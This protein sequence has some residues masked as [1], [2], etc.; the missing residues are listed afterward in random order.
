MK[1]RVIKNPLC[2]QKLKEE[3]V[4]ILYLFGS[5]LEGTSTYCS[6]VDL[7][8][9]FTHA[10]FLKNAKESLDTYVRLYDFLSDVFPRD[11][12]DIVFLQHSSLPI[13]FEA[14]TRGMAL[15][16]VSSQLRA[17]YAE[18]VIKAYIDFK[19]ILDRMD[20]LTVKSFL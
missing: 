5:Q 13:Q 6:D 1:E 2:V 18:K 16:Q 15:Y 4:G 7:G 14:V 17:A 9:V 19:P 3:K 11:R 12:V 20:K 8:V 10:Y